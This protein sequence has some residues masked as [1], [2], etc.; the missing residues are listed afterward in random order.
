LYETGFGEDGL[1]A[2]KRR[3]YTAEYFVVNMEHDVTDSRVNTIKASFHDLSQLPEWMI[4]D[5]DE[6]VKHMDKVMEQYRYEKTV[7]GK[8][9]TYAKA[10]ETNFEFV[11]KK[12]E[13]K[14][15]SKSSNTLSVKFYY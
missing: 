1:R 6:F 9:I 8:K 15:I 7:D 12:I 5:T 11:V 13:V 4:N 10:H 2:V 14:I 3:F